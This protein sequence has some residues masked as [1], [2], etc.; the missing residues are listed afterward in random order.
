MKSSDFQNIPKCTFD[1]SLEFTPSE[2]SFLAHPINVLLKSAFLIGA[3]KD[4]EG[5]FQSVFDIAEEIAKVECCAYLSADPSSGQWETVATRHV[6]QSAAQDP[7]L[8][9]PGEIARH[10]GKVI[11]LDADRDPFFRSVCETWQSSSLAVFPLRRSNECVGALAF[12]KKGNLPFTSSQ[13]KLLWTLSLHAETLLLQ[14]ETV[15]TLTF[16]SFLDPLTH[17]YNRK[18]FLNQLEREIFRSRRTGKP[19][20]MLLLDLDD[21]KAYNDKFMHSAGDIALQEFS[22]ILQNSIREVDIAAR[23]G[24]DEFAIILFE[25]NAE[26]V[27]DLAQRIIDRVHKHLL[28]GKKKHRSERL[29]VSIGTATFPSDTFDMQDLIQKAEQALSMARIQGGGKACLY[30]EIADQ[31]TI[32]SSKSDI[33]IQ[34]IYIAARSLVDI[35]GFLEILLYTAMQGISAERGSIVV[36]ETGGAVSFRTTIGFGSEEEGFS[37]GAIVPSGPVT[38]WVLENREPLIVSC[39][40]DMPLP[41]LL[42]KNGYRTDSFLSLP[43]IDNTG[44]IVGALHLSN[45]TDKRLFTRDDLAAFEPIA[46]EIASILSR[47]ILFRE[48]IRT[49]STSILHSLFRAI[50]IR[51]SFLSGHGNRVKD[52]CFRM[53]KKL[54]LGKEELTTLGTAAE[55][56]DIGVIGVPGT[57]LVKPRK[58]TDREME[59]ARRH[60]FVGSKLLEGIP[61][62]EE[63]RRAI[64]EHHECWNGAGYPYGV[65]GEQISKVGRILSVAEFYDSITS[66]RPYRGKLVPEEAMQLVSN[67]RETLFDRD[68]CAAF[69]EGM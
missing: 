58:L 10:Y 44:Q 20:S 2:I 40:D 69:L 63:I 30:H 27:H 65:K 22:T 52:H 66:D 62:T 11:L 42:K 8:L 33:P 31:L 35:D 64:L 21:F 17:L 55:L 43:L 23:Y 4:P 38:S 53:G 14:G 3:S 36:K 50:E 16:Y 68:V 13:M 49:I 29:S 32:P 61:G 54:G 26:G 12:G 19:F 47:G 51:F 1:E 24:G 41:T 28:P 37:P 59:I 15:K 5:N 7:F 6:P 34:K 48:N 56:H 18:Y 46:R 45:R 25:S 39:Q 60:P 9:V 57:I 67:S